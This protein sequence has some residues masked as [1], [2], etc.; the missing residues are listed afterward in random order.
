[1][2]HVAALLLAQLGGNASPSEADV[3]KILSSGEALM[4]GQGGGSNDM[5]A[6][7]AYAWTMQPDHAVQS[8]NWDK[9][10][11]IEQAVPLGRG[12]SSLTV[13]KWC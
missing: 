6:A 9:S 1:M 3:K 4:G 10:A 8:C 7:F 12:W 13:G 11:A 5:A 2:K